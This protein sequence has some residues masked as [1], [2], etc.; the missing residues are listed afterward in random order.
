MVQTTSQQYCQTPLRFLPKGFTPWYVVCAIAT[1]QDYGIA[2]S[3]ESLG[4]EQMVQLP[5]EKCESCSLS[6]SPYPRVVVNKELS[7]VS[8]TTAEA[9][10]IV[11]SLTIAFGL[12]TTD[13]A[14]ILRVTRQTVYAWSRGGNPPNPANNRR[15]L[16]MDRLAQYW[17]TLSVYSAKL[18][19]KMEFDHG[20]SILS[21]LQK[22][23]ISETEI[24][25]A[26]TGAAEYVNEKQAKIAQRIARGSRPEVSEA[27]MMSLEAF[28][29]KL[30]KND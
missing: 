15:L 18:A 28:I 14:S 16:Q 13:I 20:E 10:A 5:P 25:R 30:P 21:K 8:L 26:M 12:S 11:D 4:K 19:L 29:P 7:F 2:F 23:E 24:Q 27:D 6:I 1:T 9:S 3:D 17:K 22:E